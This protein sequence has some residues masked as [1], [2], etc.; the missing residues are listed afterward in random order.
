MLN[1][2]WKISKIYNCFKRHTW[3]KNIWSSNLTQSKRLTG[4]LVKWLSLPFCAR[5]VKSRLL[6]YSQS[7][8]FFKLYNKIT[9]Y[10]PNFRPDDSE[11]TLNMLDI[12]IYNYSKFGRL[13]RYNNYLGIGTKDVLPWTVWCNYN[14]CVQF[15]YPIK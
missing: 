13:N 1:I 3:N 10:K 14:I 11:N 9:D 2:F 5:Q 6:N 4:I 8:F 7:Q 15:N 12:Y